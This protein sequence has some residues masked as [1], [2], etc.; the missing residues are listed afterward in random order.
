MRARHPVLAAAAAIFAGF[1]LSAQ[2][3]EEPLAL[4]VLGKVKSIDD[5][6]KALDLEA[7]GGPFRVELPPDARGVTELKPVPVTGLEGTRTHVLG[8]EISGGRQP[9]GGTVPPSIGNV[10]TIVVGEFTPPAV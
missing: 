7:K 6:A 5:D 3:E 1:V 10:I 2:A 4:R 9:G 8:R